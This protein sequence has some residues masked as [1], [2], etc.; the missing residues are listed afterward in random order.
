MKTIINTH[1]KQI[2]KT[3]EPAEERKCNCPKTKPNCLLDGY[4]LIKNIV[5]KAN[6]T[7]ESSAPKQYIGL[8]S[9]SFK[10][11]LGNHNQSI[12]NKS[13]SH[14]HTQQNS[15][16]TFEPSRKETKSTLSSG[17]LSRKPVPTILLPNAVTSA[18][19]YHIMT[20]DKNITLNK[21]PELMGKC[22]HRDKYKLI[23][24]CMHNMT[25]L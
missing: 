24:F 23:E 18:E 13:L 21:R 15:L 11:R 4:C 25:F 14:S 1:N 6:V 3:P 9:T 12:K 10:E 20:A 17:P 8:T 7:P 16:N 19:K 22:R 5:Y 2:L